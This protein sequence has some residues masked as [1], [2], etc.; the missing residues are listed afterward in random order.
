MTKKRFE[1][2]IIS[3]V[4]SLAVLN[5]L[6]LI[7][8]FA[9]AY[10]HG[11][12][13]L[14][15]DT[16]ISDNA[17]TVSADV[18]L[19]GADITS[20]ADIRS[21]DNLSFSLNWNIDPADTTDYN[22]KVIVYDMSA[23]LPNIKLTEQTSSVEMGGVTVGKY[24]I[25]GQKLYIE[26]LTGGGV[27]N[28]S[29][30][31]SFDGNLD[32]NGISTDDQGKF[33]ISFFDKNLTFRAPENLPDTHIEK[34]AAGKVFQNSG[35]YY[36][37][38]TLKLYNSGRVSADNVTVTDTAG[39]LYIPDSISDV[40]YN[41]A[42]FTNYTVSGGNT[43][44]NIGNLPQ[45]G[46]NYDNFNTLTYTM[47]VDSAKLFSNSGDGK[48]S[49]FA[50][51]ETQPATGTVNAWASYSLPSVD[52]GGVYDAAAGKITWTIKVYPN[53]LADSTIE[54]SFTI[55]DVPDSKLL[56]GGYTA[57][58]IAA[59]IPGASE[60]G[61][62][63]TIPS[64]AFAKQ[65]DGSYKLTYTTDVADTIPQDYT[66]VSISNKAVL[67]YDDISYTDTRVP[68]VTIPPTVGVE[69]ISKDF[70]RI[71][72]GSLYWK[73]TIFV[74]DN[75]KKITVT[76][77]LSELDEY[78]D[79]VVSNSYT[80]L[81]ITDGNG[82]AYALT[83]TEEDGKIL[84]YGTVG[85]IDL[86]WQYNAFANYTLTLDNAAFFAANAGKYI[87]VTYK[88]DMPNGV[89]AKCRN[90]ANVNIEYTDST[91][92]NDSDYADYKRPVTVSKSE[93]GFWNWTGIDAESLRCGKA[94]AITLKNNSYAFTDGEIITVTEH[95][96]NG[97]EYVDGTAR[98][99]IGGVNS[100]EWQP[101]LA[102]SGSS[103]LNIT[104]S[105][106]SDIAAKLNSGKDLKLVLITQMSNEYYMDFNSS[107]TPV[108][109]SFTN[110][111]DVKV[112]GAEY[113]GTHTLS[114][115]STPS[116]ILNK[117]IVSSAMNADKKG[118]TASYKIAINSTRADLV[119]GDT[120]TV[121]D[122]LGSALQLKSGT[123][124]IEKIAREPNGYG[125]FNTVR[126]PVSSSV[127]TVSGQTLVFTLEDNTS[128]EITYDIESKP[129]S[130]LYENELNPVS[131]DPAT[132]DAVEKEL[133]RRYGN[134]VR[135]EGSGSNISSSSATLDASTFRVSSSIEF[136]I[137]INGTKTWNSNGYAFEG[138]SRPDR[139][140]VVITQK[141]DVIEGLGEDTTTDMTY[142]LI[143]DGST[144]P[145]NDPANNIY[146][147][148]PTVSGN[149]WSFNITGLTVKDRVG[150]IYSYFIREVTVNGYTT[151]YR[152]K[153]GS[154]W[155]DFNNSEFS[156]GSTTSSDINI[157]NSFVGVTDV[158]GTKTWLDGGNSLGLRPDSVS[159]KLYRNGTE[160]A[161]VPAWSNTA[162]DVWKYTYSG[163][164]KFAPDGSLYKYTVEETDVN[165]NYSATYDV[166]TLN[167]TNKFNMSQTTVITGTKKWIGGKEDSLALILKRNGTPITAVP[168]WTGTDTNTWTY[169]FSG[170]VKYY[171]KPDGS[172]A[173]CVYT[174]EEVCPDGYTSSQSGYNF[175]NTKNAPVVTTTTTEPT[176]TTTTEPTTTTTEP[177]TTTTEPTTTTTVPTTTTTVPTTT[178][179][180]PTTTTTEPTTTTTE[181]TTTTTEPTT[182][183]TEPTTTTTEP[184]TTTT[185]APSTTTAP[186]ITTTTYRNTGDIVLPI[187]TTGTS[188]EPTDDISAEAGI[189]TD[190]T[191]DS[192][193]ERM[194]SA[195]IAVLIIDA[196]SAIALTIIVRKR[197]KIEK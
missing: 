31:F 86:R 98:I 81:T 79:D 147:I 166:S 125:G 179:T 16:L 192:F 71:E 123:V 4:I 24:T 5:M 146:Y 67:R 155:R 114:I 35:K 196:V 29:G 108:T 135:I 40:Q 56:T 34:S 47:E 41:G 185:T 58:D 18:K 195:V 66:S 120:I 175:V 157:I 17:L 183:T 87:T 136:A 38:F 95:L 27:T 134:Q 156:I 42:A 190:T 12:T 169:T 68:S 115:T 9:Y 36:Q 141:K 96:P 181:P 33:N 182:T 69:Y 137:T 49:A 174:V 50:K 180:E 21:G 121:Y 25:S 20:P 39:D 103:D 99:I 73:Q 186:A 158:T 10:E 173:E 126:V 46:N 32:L 1:M 112:G 80:S 111:A 167:I 92:Q 150:T 52:K 194:S 8:P 6:I 116:D 193:G 77:S 110:K 189:I 124:V 48:N 94:W 76:D 142:H 61:G 161:A 26:I 62:T 65:S 154:T 13:E 184:T 88:T 107:T 37:K 60:T 149:D 63:I 132:A 19:N 44:F 130:I 53:I 138:E 14:N 45:N 176:T 55:K 170:L 197:R 129:D 152:Y 159:L 102:V 59:A 113:S 22:D 43:V 109:R 171:T 64:S 97:M 105:V 145:A 90:N 51:P 93:D 28:R 119:P 104:I 2:R 133:G 128:Y 3:F 54:D 74:P 162:G 11:K 148:R 106:N 85:T 168:T 163:L 70:E 160:Y 144:L 143:L 75:T 177:T 153:D 89:I 172:I 164:P 191:S 131:P 100:G 82:V 139:I 84:H 188:T 30:S 151:T 127:M 83:G 72:D 23:K 165:L 91:N 140:T 187:F 117:S 178:T 15:A 101:Q 122:T 78:S 57:A 7:S 118:F